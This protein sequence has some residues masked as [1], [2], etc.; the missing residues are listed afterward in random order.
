MKDIDNLDTDPINMER[1]GSQEKN[2]GGAKPNRY[3]FQEFHVHIYINNTSLNVDLIE[4]IL[5]IILHIYI[6]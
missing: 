2:P 1:N 3:F 4:F 5:Q 6:G